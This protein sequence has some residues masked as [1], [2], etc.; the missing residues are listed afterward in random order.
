MMPRA[1]DDS[2][3]AGRPFFMRTALGRAGRYRRKESP[4]GGSLGQ[5]GFFPVS[6]SA[7]KQSAS[8]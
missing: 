1:A 4:R 3:E 6:V 7:A 5:A 8:L 2:T